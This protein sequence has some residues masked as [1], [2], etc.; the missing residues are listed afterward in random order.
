MPGEQILGLT[1][2][3]ACE[4]VDHPRAFAGDGEAYFEAPLLV[5]AM[6]GELR[7]GGPLHAFAVLAVV[8]LQNSAC[9]VDGDF[10]V[11]VGC[12]LDEQGDVIASSSFGS[13]GVVVSMWI[14]AMSGSWQ[15]MP[16]CR[17][18]PSRWIWNCVAALGC[19]D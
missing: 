10:V 15:M 4:R 14:P 11:A 7:T 18:L 8:D 5:A 12:G 13:S 17:M 2:L 1:A 16:M 6:H 9:G 19:S 3:D